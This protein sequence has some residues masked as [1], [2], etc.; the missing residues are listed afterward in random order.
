MQINAP[1]SKKWMR[2]ARYNVQDPRTR[3][4]NRE[5][6]WPLAGQPASHSAVHTVPYTALPNSTPMQQNKVP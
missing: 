4:F 1:F 2:L 6:G 3:V 5:G